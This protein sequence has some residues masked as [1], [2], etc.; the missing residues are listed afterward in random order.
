M[1]GEPV[2]FGCDVGKMMRR[3][4]G[5]WDAELFDYEALYDTTFTL[6]KAERLDL[7]RDAR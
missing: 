6:D 3:D 5:I 4:L 7:P 2:W 1:G